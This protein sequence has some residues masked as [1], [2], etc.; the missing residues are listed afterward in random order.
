MS[1]AGTGNTKGL[2][3][4]GSALLVAPFL[5]LMALGFLY[6]LLDLLRL[7]VAE[8]ELGLSNYQRLVEEPVYARVFLRTVWIAFATAV[9][10]L[11]LGFPVAWFM[12]RASGWTAAIVAICVLLPFWSSVLVRTAAWTIIL[13]REGIINNALTGTGLV[14]QPLTL[15]YTQ[16]AVLIG[17]THALI[18]FMILPLYG[19]LRAIPKDLERAA[20]VMGAGRIAVFV[21][22]ILPIARA[23][24]VTGFLIVFLTALGFFITPALLGSPQE[25]MIV[26][27]VSQQVREVLDWPFAAAI[28]SALTLA[29]VVIAS[30]FSRY[31]AFDRVLGGR[32]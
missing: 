32:S 23:G 11:I 20:Q 18:P 22:I 24:I 29:V 14:S 30:L 9:L 21:E 16:G 15:L 3:A 12:A 27:L 7:S 17:M 31:L 5:I 25:Q 1:A 8:P 19:A 2:G 10:A 6:P 13:G 4:A 28:V 26:T